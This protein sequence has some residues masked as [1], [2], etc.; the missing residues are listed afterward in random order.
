MIKSGQI[1]QIP[2]DS[3]IFE[4]D[5][6]VLDSKKDA[7][8]KAVEVRNYGL[9]DGFLIGEH[10][11]TENFKL[12]QRKGINVGGKKSPLYVI[13]IS[14]VTNQ[15]FVGE[16]EQHPGLWIKVIKVSQFPLDQMTNPS[17]EEDSKQGLKVQIHSALTDEEAPASLYQFEEDVFLEFDNLV[18]IA[19]QDYPFEIRFEDHYKATIRIN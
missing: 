19:I 5:V 4:T 15:L 10:Q 9:F 1:V 3:S 7:L 11:G 14:H 12:G 18:P 16:G 8:T 17:T 13:G 6:S 2:L